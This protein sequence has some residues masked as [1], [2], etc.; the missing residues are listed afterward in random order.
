MYKVLVQCIYI[1]NI[2]ALR[3]GGW[4]LGVVDVWL[5]VAF[6]ME[7][8]KL[9]PKQRAHATNKTTV[10]HPLIITRLPKS[11][12][13]ELANSSKENFAIFILVLYNKR[14]LMNKSNYILFCMTC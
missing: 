3:M 12:R 9:R 11:T 10:M 2:C 7:Q 6:R 13:R 1:Y 5:Y 8:T 4:W 14:I